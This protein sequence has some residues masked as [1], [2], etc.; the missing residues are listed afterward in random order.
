M[1]ALV[2]EPGIGKSR[3]A[4]EM[5]HRAESS[6]FATAWTCSRS[7]ASAFPYHLVS[8]LA[9]QLL[10]E[11][12]A[13]STADALRGAGGDAD[14]D[15]LTDGPPS[16]TTC[17]ATAPRT[18][19]AGRPVTG[20]KAADPGARHRRPAQAGV[21]AQADA[22]R[23]RRPP[24]GRS[25]QPRGRG[26][27]PQHPAGPARRAAGDVSV[28]LVARL[29]GPQLLRADQHS[30]AA[31]R[32]R[33][34]DGH[35]AGGRPIAFRRSWQS[36][37]SSAPAATR[38]SSRSLSTGSAAQRPT[39]GASAAGVDPRD[40]PR[41]ARRPAGR[42]ATRA[43]ARI[44]GRHGVLDGRSSP[45]AEADADRRTRRSAPPAARAHPSGGRDHTGSCSATR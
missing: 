30:P 14:G 33:A 37:S 35:G 3:L 43:P 38:S 18:T 41:P 27:A 6:G 25:G 34:R 36:G 7:Y 45:L 10:D 21:A 17:S 8:Q 5:L 20:G 31:A 16:S 26:G 15:A 44:R 13:Q 29:G 23:P 24:L 2:G 1:V 28:E 11:R 9:P 32:R 40:A 39:A 42:C 22:A 4:L 12:R 19:R